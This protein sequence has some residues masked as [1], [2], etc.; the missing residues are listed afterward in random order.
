MSKSATRSAPLALLALGVVFG[1]IGTS[2]LYAFRMC[3]DPDGG[4]SPDRAAVMGVLALVFWSLTVVVSLKY[5]AYLL[6]A[7]LYG[8]GGI[9]ALM[10]LAKPS[11]EPRRT[12]PVFVFVLGIFGAALL[13]G[14][15]MITP[16][17]SVLSAV[18]GLAVGTAELGD[19]VIPI[20]LGV[21]FG[22]FVV[23]RHGTERVGH[24]FGPVMLVWFFV[25]FALGARWI[26]EAPEVLLAVDPRYAIELLAEHPERAF[27]VLGFVFLVVT[28]GEALYADLGHFGTR[29]I[30]VAWF[31][32]A[33]P[34]VAVNYFGQGALV[35]HDPAAASHSFYAMVPGWALYPMVALATGAAIIASQAVISGAFSLTFQAIRLGYAP[36]IDMRHYAED[37]EGRVYV[38]WVNWAL[39]SMSAVLVLGFGSSAALAGA[40][41]VAVST[42][43]V[44]TTVLAWIVFGRRWGWI[45]A[46]AISAALL[47]FDLSFLFSNLGKILEGGWFPLVVSLVVFGVLTTWAKGRKLELERIDAL[48]QDENQWLEQLDEDPPARVSGTA[49][50]FGAE[51]TGIPRT[52]VRNLIH[53][54]VL[55]KTVVIFSV[56]T[57]RI[58][59]VPADRR[60]EVTSIRPGMLRVKAR[61]GYMQ[62]PH[63]PSVLRG[64]DD[65]VFEY[66]QDNTT[67]FVGA[68]ELIV[69][70]ARGMTRWR[71]RLFAFLSRNALDATVAYRVPADRT[72]ALGVRVKL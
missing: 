28:G 52:L 9:L 12:H 44:I 70:T 48:Q 55:H 4:L 58:P 53:N 41:G 69:T 34:A 31:A 64:I 71:K 49:V 25:L 27:R 62:T 7:D 2:P 33:F 39:F 24:F 60:T 18:E 45:P 19:F 42:T 11:G 22:V 29:P 67:F 63:V 51:P 15:G 56:V 40:Y 1:D 8:E 13:Y 30:R 14:D 61:Y 37:G 21:L 57:E 20:T 65:A 5:L 17:I 23:Q 72:I 26:F 68:D 16:A 54:R 46:T 66:D 50:F 47:V 6:R 32:V 59:R 35:L 38:P 36:R 43:M 3:F 10:T